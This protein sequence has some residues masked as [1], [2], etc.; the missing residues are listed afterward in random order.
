M[1]LFSIY[2]C[3]I[4]NAERHGCAA[5]LQMFTSQGW[6]EHGSLGVMDAHPLPDDEGERDLQLLAREIRRRREQLGWSQADLAKAA[7]LSPM[8]IYFVESAKRRPRY[9]TLKR[10]SRALG[11]HVAVLTIHTA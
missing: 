6:R 11:C 9:D 7:G 1:K 2:S 8:C 5:P 4:F 3:L 10:I